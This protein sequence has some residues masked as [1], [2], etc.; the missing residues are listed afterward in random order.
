MADGDREQQRGG[1]LV[2]LLILLLGVVAAMVGIYSYAAIQARHF[3]EYRALTDTLRSSTQ[4]IS[5]YAGVA[6]SGDVAAF[7]ILQKYRDRGEEAI[8]QLHGGS[9]ETGLPALSLADPG[10]LEEVAVQWRR[11]RNSAD[12]ILA[13]QEEIFR[14]QESLQALRQS[15]PELISVSEEI[16]TALVQRGGNAGQVHI[17][18]RQLVLLQRI[19]RDLELIS[20]GGAEG[21]QA[22]ERLEQNRTLFTRVVNGMLKRDPELGVTAVRD[23]TIRARLEQLQALTEGLE[24][25]REAIRE[26][27]PV[28]SRAGAV[29]DDINT[30]V[31]QMLGAVERLE[32]GYATFDDQLQRWSM[33]NYLLGAAALLLLVLI[34]L[35]LRRE[36][37]LRLLAIEQQRRQSEEQNQRNQQA[38]LRLLDEMGNLADGDLTVQA[39][40]TEDITGA[41]ADSVNYAVDALRHLV[42][43][44]NETTAQVS[45]AAQDVQVSTQQ[46]AVDSGR[47]AEQIHELARQITDMAGAIEKISADA[48]VL[49]EEAKC[50]V[51]SAARGADAVRNNLLGMDTIREQIQ[52]TSKR[53]KRLGESSQE[54]GNIVELIKDI[55]EQTNIL[56][57]NAS[58]QAAMEGESGRAFAVV[59]E[60][61]Q[62]LAERS[63][64]A[65][66]DIEILVRTI[67]TDTSEAVHSMEQ[68]TQGVVNGTRL[69]QEAG[70]NLEDIDRVAQHLAE[71]IQSISNDARGYAESASGVSSA[72]SEIQSLSLLTSDG[73]NRA[74]SAIGHL[75]ESVNTLKRSVA[76]FKLPE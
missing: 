16:A 63:A 49:A 72:M 18:T 59:A 34:A 15:L 2:I 66:R 37:R 54:I 31:E 25:R 45:S 53:M 19:G 29:A 55:A 42:R 9:T 60:E 40:V 24:K 6:A 26:A 38:I 4:Q 27:L 62:R 39:T 76:G 65:T 33:F 36:D 1:S 11:Y 70:R 58:L 20:A 52:E 47:Q 23:R 57:L 7:S 68:S 74:T 3:Q 44:I 13:Y 10:V 69:A 43:S 35:Q 8:L 12:T 48:A 41:I 61:V 14:L 28:V 22:M 46:L 56:A 75:A 67:Q 51:E 64:G 30:S 71:L 73:L 32:Q 21:M 17:A 5:K 50:S